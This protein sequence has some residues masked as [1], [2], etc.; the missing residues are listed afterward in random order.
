M[1]GE[2]SSRST[3]VGKVLGHHCITEKIGEGGMGDVYRARDQRLDRDVAIKVLRSG[4][5]SEGNT[6]KHFRKEALALSGLNHPNIE[7]IH[8]FDS[9]NGVG[10]LVTEYKAARASICA[11]SRR[12]SPSCRSVAAPACAPSASC[13]LSKGSSGPHHRRHRAG[14]RTVAAYCG[15]RDPTDTGS[16]HHLVRKLE[17]R[18]QRCLQS[19]VPILT[20]DKTASNSSRVLTLL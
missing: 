10:F 2:A 16:P 3:I 13:S 19:A 15:P 5:L 8:D 20:R 9:D 18:A 11:R 1:A 14:R 7:T 6:R 4:A 12:A 17:R